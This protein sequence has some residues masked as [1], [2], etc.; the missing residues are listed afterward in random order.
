[1][2]TCEVLG[3]LVVKLN[4]KECTPRA[5][6]VRQ[7]LALALFRA[8]QTV[9]LDAIIE[10]L[11]ADR[12][13]RTAVTTVQT[14]VYQIRKLIA[15]HSGTRV[16]N[17]T[18]RTVTPGYVL[19]IAD[20]GLDFRRFERAFEQAQVHLAN[21]Q[22]QEAAALL[23]QALSMWNAPVLAD[24]EHGQHLRAHVANLEE[25]RML[26]LEMRLHADMLLG[27]HRQLVGELKSL[28][29]SHPFNEWLHAQLMIA[30]HRSGRR[31][32]A[33]SAYQYARRLLNDELGLEPSA[34]L[35]LTHQKVLRADPLT[36]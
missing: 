10:E 1:M 2:L 25:K 36:I 20:E 34:D 21:R 19:S 30:L 9:S 29:I 33:L 32:E 26:A 7:V 12:P 14:Y 16:A 5:A 3:P 13:P 28:V 27:R 17:Q 6:K 35:Q 8:N 24:T 31:G 4:N 22:T 11:W 23:S 18:L 15:Q